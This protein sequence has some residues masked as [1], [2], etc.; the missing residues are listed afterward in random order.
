MRAF[1]IAGTIAAAVWQAG[2]AAAGSNEYVFSLSWQPA[3]CETRPQKTECKSMTPD[4]YDAANVVLHG[5]WPQGAQ[6]C[7]VPAYIVAL[8]NDPGRWLDM[9]EVAMKPE[10][11]QELATY[12]PGVASGLHL[13]EWYKHGTCSG[14]S[15]DGYFGLSVT[16][17][18]SAATASFGKLLHGSVG[19]TI[20]GQQLCEALARDYGDKASQL[21]KLIVKNGTFSEIRFTLQADADKTT[22]LN[23]THMLPMGGARCSTTPIRIDAAGN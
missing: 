21:V 23:A 2:P 15:P 10:T 8:D 19:A 20:T 17:A 13:H 16:L 3:F 7:G 1:V 11:R 5:L 6:F 9:P 18:K 22:A 4:R 12:M 14:L